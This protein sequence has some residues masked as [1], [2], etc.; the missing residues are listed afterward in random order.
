MGPRA[1]DLAAAAIRAYAPA[2]LSPEA[3]G[4]ARSAAARA[5]PRTRERAK[6]LL[7]AAGRLAAF[8]ESVGMELCAETLLARGDDRALRPHAAARRSRRRRGAR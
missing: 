2:S 6:A 7:Y 3:A 8:G 4:F 5:A 1:A